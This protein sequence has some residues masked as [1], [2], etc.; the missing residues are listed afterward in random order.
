[1]TLS[2]LIAAVY[3]ETNRPDLVPETMQSVLEATLS[4]HLSD[5]Y[6]IDIRTA[7]V[8]FDDPTLFIQQL[9]TQTMPFYRNI[10]FIRKTNPQIMG[11]EQSQSL[12]PN[13]LMYPPTQFNFLRRVDI[14]NIL[15]EFGYELRDIY[16]QAGN[17]INIK[18]SS[19]LQYAMIGWYAY[20][21][22]DATGMNFNSWI[23]KEL[24]YVIIY[25][26]AGAIYSKIGED[27]SW[28]IYMKPYSPGGG[29][30]TGGS[31]WQQLAIL[32]KLNIRASESIR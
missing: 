13:N 25:K 9:D 14:G 18:S 29:Y 12:L 3:T 19:A 30:E 27:K 7:M 10:A 26:A 24:P 20:P 1:M 2:E 31:Y 22:L 21:N 11:I 16:Y 8:V 23:A 28:A 32:Q 4:A 17:S 6:C 5:N 15:D